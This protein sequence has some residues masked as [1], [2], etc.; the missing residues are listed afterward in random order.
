MKKSPNGL[1]VMGWP[2]YRVR[3]S[4]STEKDKSLFLL[5]VG[6]LQPYPLNTD[7]KLLFF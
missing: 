5:R 3:F 2:S 7:H 4:P 6:I 1:W